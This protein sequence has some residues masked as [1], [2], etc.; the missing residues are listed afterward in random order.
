MALAQER[1]QAIQKKAAQQGRSSVCRA[2]KRVAW[3][4]PNPRASREHI[5]IVRTLRAKGTTQATRSILFQQPAKQL[6]VTMRHNDTLALPATHAHQ[7]MVS[8][9]RGSR[10][11]YGR[12]IRH[13]RTVL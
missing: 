12:F 2:F 3:I 10:A 5:L 8:F 11:T 13:D 6:C 1:S 9:R 7:P 4:G